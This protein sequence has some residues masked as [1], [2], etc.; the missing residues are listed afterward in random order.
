MRNQREEL[1][2]VDG[3]RQSLA[4]LRTRAGMLPEGDEVRGAVEAYLRT[5]ELKTQDRVEALS[6]SVRS[7]HKV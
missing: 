1:Q 5:L 7:L 4:V 3:V 6:E 2:L